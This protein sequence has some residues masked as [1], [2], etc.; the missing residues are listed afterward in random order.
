M[1]LVRSISRYSQGVL[2]RELLNRPWQPGSLVAPLDD[3]VADPLQIVQAEIAAILDDQL[4][5]AGCA[6]A[7][8]RRRPEYRTIAPRT[9]LDSGFAGPRRSRRRSDPGRAARKTP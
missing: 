3:L 9:G 6:Q 8:D 4:E 5:A 2:A 7:V 1:H